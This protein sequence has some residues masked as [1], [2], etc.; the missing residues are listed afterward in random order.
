[1]YEKPAE[2][3][4]NIAALSYLVS[5]QCSRSVYLNFYRAVFFK[6]RNLKSVRI[7]I[8]THYTI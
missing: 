2:N 6:W 4:M 5:G 1:M 8:Y 7:K 3:F